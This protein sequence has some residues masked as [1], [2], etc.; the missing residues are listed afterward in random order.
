MAGGRNHGSFGER[1][2][3]P[4]NGPWS[5]GLSLAM[6]R[7]ARAVLGRDGQA[8]RLG[9]PTQAMIRR[10]HPSGGPGAAKSEVL[11]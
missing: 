4:P 7:A 6:R 1:I 8:G 2:S 5:Y 9:R 11:Q 3:I 10:R